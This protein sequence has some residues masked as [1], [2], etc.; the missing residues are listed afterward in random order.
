MEA[1]ENVVRIRIEAPEIS[2]TGDMQKSPP[3]SAAD[4]AMAGMSFLFSA[5][6]LYLAFSGS[7]LKP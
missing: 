1:L 6:G 4:W 7:I 5:V 3:S 2:L